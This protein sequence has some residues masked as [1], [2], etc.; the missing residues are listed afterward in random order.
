MRFPVTSGGGGERWTCGL[1]PFGHR[2]V[3]TE[4]M[5]SAPMQDAR[6]SVDFIGTILVS[7][8]EYSIIGKDLEG[9]ILLWNEGARRNYG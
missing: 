4:L 2:P 5:D 8:T 6:Q 7:P 9:D 1:R 3:A